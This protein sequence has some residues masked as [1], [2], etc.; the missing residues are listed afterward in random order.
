MRPGAGGKLAGD[1]EA[2]KVIKTHQVEPAGARGEILH[3]CTLPGEI[4]TAR[5]AEKSLALI[6]N[7]S[8]QIAGAKLDR[9]GRGIFDKETRGMRLHICEGGTKL[10]KSGRASGSSCS[11]GIIQIR[12]AGLF[13][14]IWAS[15]TPS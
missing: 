10:D 6:E 1:S 15:T 2:Q 12:R 5:I 8:A 3:L 7:A 14:V 9:A 11:D 4:S 13:Y